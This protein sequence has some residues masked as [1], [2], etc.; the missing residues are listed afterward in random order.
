QR[1]LQILLNV[2]SNA[3]KFT[4]VGTINIRARHDNDTIKIAVQDTGPGIAPEDYHMVFESFK[5][6]ESGQRHGQ[7]TGLGMPISKVL[8][9]AHGGRLW[10]ESEP[11]HG[12]TFYVSLPVCSPVLE[13]T[14]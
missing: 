12:T 7:G 14:E 6:T 5:Q 1:I 11:G 10:F 13:L 4:T 8:A 9:E 3:C 2:L